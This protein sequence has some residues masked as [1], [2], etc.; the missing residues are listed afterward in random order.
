MKKSIVRTSLLVMAGSLFATLNQAAAAEAV[1]NNQS[2][3]FDFEN[4]DLEGW[5]IVSGKFGNIVTDRETFHD[6]NEP[7]NRQGKWHLS[8]LDGPSG[9]KSDA[10][11]GELRSKTFK[12]TTPRVNFLVGGGSKGVYVALCTEDG[13]EERWVTGGD[14]QKMKRVV[15]SL[16]E[17]VG[18]DVFLKIV[19]R[20]KG[21]WGHITFDDFRE[22]GDE[23]DVVEQVKSVLPKIPEDKNLSDDWIKA[24]TARGKPEVWSGD[25]LNYI[26][27]PI[28]GIGCGQLYL[29]GDGRLWL[30]D[31]FKSNYTRE[32]VNSLKLSLMTMNGHYTEPVDSKTGTYSERNGADV[33]QGFAIRI[34][35]NDAV[36]LRTLDSEGFPGVSFRGEYPIGRVT[37]ADPKSPVKVELEAFSPFIP[38][39]AKDS[40]LPA[41][42]MTY[43]VTNTSKDPLEVDLMG[44]LQNATCPHDNVAD[45]GERR[46]TLIQQQGLVTLHQTVEP[47]AGKGLEKHHGYGSMA[48]SLIKPEQGALLGAAQTNLPLDAGAFANKFEKGSSV[49]HALDKPLVG[50]LGQSL[51][52]AAGESRQ[53]R[54]LLTW[55][56]P[57]HQKKGEVDRGMN[58]IEDFASMKRHYAPW[59]TSAADAAQKIEKDYDRLAGGT[60]RWNETWYDSTL[61]YWFLDR[62]FIPIDCLATQTFHW[63]DSGRPWGWEG[64]D[65]CPG[66]C[67]HVWSYAHAMGRIFPEFER[68]I[69]EHV[70]YD[71]AMSENGGIAYRGQRGKT[72][73]TDGQAGVILRTL[74]EHQMSADSEFLTR[75]WPQTKKAVEFLLRQDP[76]KQGVL[77]GTQRHTLDATWEGPMGWMSSLYCAAL[78]AGAQ[79]A[80][81]MGDDEFA[82][83]CTKVADRGKKNI[84]DEVFNGEYFIHKPPNFERIN[85]N[86]GSHI[87]QVLGQSWAW[88]VGLPRVLPKKETDSALNALW[89]YNFA[90]DAG[91]YARE[92]TFI[93]GAR[94]YADVGEAGMIMTGWPQG[95]SE[96]AVPG[97][98]RRVENF[99]KWLGAG[100]Y[101]DE[102]MSGFEYQVASHMIYEGKPDSEEVK[103]GLAVA[104]AIHDRYNAAKRNLYNEI[105][106]GD[107]YSRAM[108]AYG[109]YLAVCGYQYHGP[110]GEI[111]FAP[112]LQP[113]DFRAAFTATEGWGTY[114]QKIIRKQMQAK[115]KLN[116]G[117]LAIQTIRL[118]PQGTTMRQV[119]V[120]AHGK[121]VNASVN[122]DQG[123][124][125]VRLTSPVRIAT[126]QELVVTLK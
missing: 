105:E 57:L 88:Q 58:R 20:N 43:T 3:L 13:K 34:V 52:L 73:A 22:G 65:S 9:T 51:K 90:P 125:V 102:V 98:A 49:S 60:R 50:T 92:H 10:Y 36:E 71:I 120:I 110:K 118:D 59:F 40:S 53:V 16:P 112:R 117:S 32:N 7:H 6:S 4:G 30:W 85:T 83:L 1:D 94:V 75:V 96:V 100:G 24:L 28:G 68:H 113:E 44:W 86:I 25:E 72:A 101:F 26:G 5:K 55:Y 116:N 78:R 93:K 124:A 14:S 126:G 66:T 81:E 108:A 29:A 82:E 46:N 106:C 107:H 8:T 47:A 54:F 62:A 99:E 80:E 33:E 48:L 31:I 39:S 111:G 121:K 64:V 12:L 77:E 114:S 122:M 45:L 19:D 70:D 69:R 67:T 95:G 89:K 38:L 97:M 87:D 119:S 109:A 37:Y 2:A 11:V 74:R 104:R 56:F 15:W 103:R 42:V 79:M 17:L 21:G 27:M 63:F 76:K 123:T 41:T 91:G 18:E 84:V 61:P 23:R 35:Q 115:L